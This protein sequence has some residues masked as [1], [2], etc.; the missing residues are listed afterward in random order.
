MKFTRR[1][2]L[3]KS[4][5]YGT[6]LALNFDY[7]PVYSAFA[8]NE[9]YH[10]LLLGDP[11]LS[12]REREVPD[13]QK[14]QRIIAAKI[15][16]AA[17]VSSWSKVDEITVLGDVAAQFGN[18]IER[19]WA[20]EFFMQF[21]QPI[22]FINGNHD[23]I[24]QDAFS[25]KKKFVQSD[26][27]SRQAKLQ[28]FQQAFS[29]PNL[30][31]SRNIGCYHLVYLSPDSLTTH[32]LAEISQEQLT[33]LRNDL[34]LHKEKPTI[35][36]FHA[37][38]AGTLLS[39]N[40]QVNSADFIAQPKQEIAA[41]LQENKQIVLWV[42]GH[43]HTPATNPSYAHP[44]NYYEGRLLNLHNADLDREEIWTNSLFLAKDRITI[45]TFNH[46]KD[47]WEEKFNREVLW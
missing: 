8:Q 17:T 1:Q 13:E 18:D 45:R 30:Y 33:W 44:V 21:P 6:M 34:A 11:H 39:Y 35:V 28:K 5:V 37:P 46:K 9:P 4:L 12:V 41:L 14:Q 19:E 32:H 31:Y 42:S 38:L 29:L 25:I 26:M 36:F 40:K 22:Y 3:Q 15:S 43:T 10:I 27:A 23:Y 20:K 2:F 16:L 24:Y 47:S 7:R